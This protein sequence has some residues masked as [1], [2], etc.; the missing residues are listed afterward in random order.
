MMTKQDFEALAQAL[1]AVGSWAESPA[2]LNQWEHDCNAVAVV[3][4]FANPKFDR[5]K[6]LKACGVC[7]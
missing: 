1:W 4:E 5:D 7:G 2:A 3:C 6:F